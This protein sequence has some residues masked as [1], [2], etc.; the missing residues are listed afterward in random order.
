MSQYSPDHLTMHQKP[1]S[2]CN[3]KVIK[4]TQNSELVRIGSFQIPPTNPYGSTWNRVEFGD[5]NEKSYRIS[6]ETHCPD[7]L[8]MPLSSDRNLRL[9]CSTDTEHGDVLDEY[10][11]Y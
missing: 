8:L 11:L 7:R 1:E 6:T 9:E 5:Y 3:C 10:I 4:W 2:L